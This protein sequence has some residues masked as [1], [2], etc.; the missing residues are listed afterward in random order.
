DGQEFILHMPHDVHFLITDLACNKGSCERHRIKGPLFLLDASC[1][2][3]KS[4]SGTR[5]NI[6]V[7]TRWA[8]MP[9]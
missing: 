3:T 8:G 6:L 4:P 1:K 5:Y 9:R 2:W 7:T